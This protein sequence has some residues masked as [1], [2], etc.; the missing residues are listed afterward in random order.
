M[1]LRQDL[2]V[3]LMAGPP[4]PTPQL[5]RACEPLVSFKAGYEIFISGAG[6]YVAGGVG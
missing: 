3:S 4:I 2:S 1:L 6:E 5:I